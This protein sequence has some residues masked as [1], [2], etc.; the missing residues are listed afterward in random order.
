LCSDA[1]DF[2]MGKFFIQGALTRVYTIHLSIYSESKQE[3]RV[4]EEKENSD[5]PEWHDA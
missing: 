3:V 4:K 2:K 5:F 1:A